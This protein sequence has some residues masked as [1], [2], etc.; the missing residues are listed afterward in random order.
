MIMVVAEPYSVIE[1]AENGKHLCLSR[2]FLRIMQHDEILADIPLADIAVVILSARQITL[3]RSILAELASYNVPLIT[4][5]HNYL[6]IAMNLP[7]TDNHLFSGRLHLQAAAKPALKRRIWQKIVRFKIT[8]QAN[9]LHLANHQRTAALLKKIALRVTLGDST[10]LEA[11]AAQI[12]WKTLFGKDFIRNPDSE[13]INSFLNYGYAIIRACTGRAICATGLS[14]ALGVHHHNKRNPFCLADDLM[15]PYRPLIDYLTW[16]L[17]QSG[18]LPSQLDTNHKAKL[19]ES[20]K[21]PLITTGKT[22]NIN[23]ALQNL[24]FSLVKCYNDNSDA[25]E[26]AELQFKS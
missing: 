25:V 15:E 5:G 8:H 2:G 9:L 7:I 18:Q 1:I 21:F 16:Q 12:Y 19:T 14:P 22:T 20:L 13:G 26:I 24:A 3:T 4:T 11:R 23:H 10:N 17:W 6:P